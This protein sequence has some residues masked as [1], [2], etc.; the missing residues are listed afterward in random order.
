MHHNRQ[1]DPFLDTLRWAAILV[2]THYCIAGWLM[3]IR[4]PSPN[5]ERASSAR[6]V[7]FTVAA[8]GTLILFAT[9]YFKFVI[10]FVD[11]EWVS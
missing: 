8:G 2:P 4:Q 9:F 5:G 3:K 10:R 7:A 11:G 6:L 1:Q